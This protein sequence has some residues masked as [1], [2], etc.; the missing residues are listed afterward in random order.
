MLADCS[1]V[2]TTAGGEFGCR[3]E[4]FTPVS[5]HSRLLMSNVPSCDFRCDI[6]ESGGRGSR[7]I[8]DTLERPLEETCGADTRAFA[9]SSCILESVRAAGYVTGVLVQRD[10]DLHG[11]FLVSDPL[12]LSQSDPSVSL[13]VSGESVHTCIRSFMELSGNELNGKLFQKEHYSAKE[14]CKQ[15]SPEQTDDRF[16]IVTGPS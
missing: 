14:E 10:Q 11:S 9:V 4:L 15:E 8:P 3:T 7:R 2:L 16:C 12:Y 13:H 5:T 1:A 6:P